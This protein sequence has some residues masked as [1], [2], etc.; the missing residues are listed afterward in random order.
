[1]CL[2]ALSDSNFEELPD[3]FWAQAS[4][5]NRHGFGVMYHDGADLRIRAHMHYDA[6]LVLAELAAVPRGTQAAVHLR[7]AT[8]GSVD[9]QNLHPQLLTFSEDAFF[10]LAVMHNGCM[11]S[12]GAKVG[13]GPS[14]TML[15]VH[16][17]LRQR[18]HAS[19]RAW[20]GDDTQR[21]LQEVVGP[22]NRLVMLDSDGHWRCIGS[23]QGFRAGRTW[24][25]NAKA[26][27]WL[28]VQS[29]VLS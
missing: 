22:N 27:V 17:W 18:V 5:A 7:N 25:S 24:V 23:E 1:M 2:I 28:P 21:H 9:D 3:A 11:P 29:A 16:G 19:P 14:D 8:F 4:A 13:D 6:D 10:A 12:M 20:C 15:L 26:Q